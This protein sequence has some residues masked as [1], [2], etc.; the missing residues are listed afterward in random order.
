MSTQT[1]SPPDRLDS[2]SATPRGEGWVAFAIVYLALVGILNVIY[3]IAAL[4]NKDYFNSGGLL[5]AN[6]N[7]WGWVSIVLG[8][9]QLFVAGMLYARSTFAAVIAIFLASLAFIANF[10]AIGAYPVWS[11]IAMVLDGFVIWALTV[12]TIDRAA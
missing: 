5:W 10:L 7:T 6:L 8:A 11:V 1:H 3:G 12:N 4:S 9:F 2:R